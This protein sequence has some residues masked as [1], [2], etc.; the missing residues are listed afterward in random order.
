MPENKTVINRFGHP[1]ADVYFGSF[2]RSEHARLAQLLNEL[3]YAPD[4]LVRLLSDTPAIGALSSAEQ[5]EMRR[6]ITLIE[7]QLDAT[8]LKRMPRWFWDDTRFYADARQPDFVVNN[9]SPKLKQLLMFGMLTDA[10]NAFL[11]RSTFFDHRSLT[12]V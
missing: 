5:R 10:S 12:I 1:F 4:E 8:R 11:Q 3:T 7:D 6:A 2:G 9:D